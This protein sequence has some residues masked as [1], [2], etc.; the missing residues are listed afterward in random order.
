[1]GIIEVD[2]FS[3]DVNSLDHPKAIRF[4][5]LLEGVA[6]EYHCG[7]LSFSVQHGTVSFSFDD[8]LL[9]AK[10]LKMLG[11]EAPTE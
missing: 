4:K 3:E 2:V 11:A 5:R 1:M 10:I 8:D 9:T 7:L 6:A